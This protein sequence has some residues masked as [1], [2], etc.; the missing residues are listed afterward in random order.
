[1]EKIN[2]QVAIDDYSTF[3]YK[4]EL[5]VSKETFYAYR[6]TPRFNSFLKLMKDEIQKLGGNVQL[7]SK[8]HHDVEIDGILL[9]GKIVLQEEIDAGL[10]DIPSKT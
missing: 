6:V 5:N 7:V 2:L 3:N 10:I 4:I 9:D 8:N 1:M